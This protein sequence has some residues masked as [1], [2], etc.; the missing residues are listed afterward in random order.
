MVEKNVLAM[1]TADTYEIVNQYS[2][3]AYPTGSPYPKP[4]EFFIPIRKK[5]AMEYLYKVIKTIE[6]LPDDIYNCHEMLTQEQYN[7]LIAYHETRERGFGY[8]SREKKYRFCILEKIGDIEQPFVKKNVQVSFGLSLNDVPLQKSSKIMATP[9]VEFFIEYQGRPQ[10]ADDL[11]AYTKEVLGKKRIKQLSLYYQPENNITYY[12]ADGE[13]GSF[14]IESDGWYGSIAL[15]K[16][17]SPR[18]ENALFIGTLNLP[19]DIDVKSY[20]GRKRIGLFYNRDKFAELEY[21]DGNYRLFTRKSFLEMISVDYEEKTGHGKNEACVSGISRGNTELLGK[22]ISLV[23][24]GF[25]YD[26]VEVPKTDEEQERYVKKTSTKELVAIAEACSTSTPKR[27]VT[28]VETYERKT[29]IRDCV[30]RMANGVCQLCGKEAPFRKKDGTPY[31]E[32]HHIIWL[33]DGGAD[34]LENTVALCPNC[35]RKMHH[36]ND[37]KDIEILQKRKQKDL[38]D[39]QQL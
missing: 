39:S 9:Q 28:T 3:H 2:I 19:A 27:T 11:V 13:E 10:S 22:V 17:E 5:G 32:S 14:T 25:E 33:K 21:T 29:F 18:D 31:L 37:P 1:A 4:R 20:T 16:Y 30:L 7:R 6:F 8:G 38:M 24:G 36:L 15:K 12:V 26:T 35:H 34:S 23:K